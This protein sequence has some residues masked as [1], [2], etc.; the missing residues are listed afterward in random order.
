LAFQAELPGFVLT[1]PAFA[2]Y[3][4]AAMEVSLLKLK[5]KDRTLL[6]TPAGLSCSEA[7][8][9]PASYKVK[10]PLQWNKYSE[11]LLLQKINEQGVHGA[12]LSSKWENGWVSASS[13]IVGF[14]ALVV[15]T[16]APQFQKM[17]T[18][19]DPVTGALLWKFTLAD[20]CSG[21]K[22]ISLSLDGHW[23]VGEY[24]AS[25]TVIQARPPVDYTNCIGPHMLQLEYSDK[26]GNS[27]VTTLGF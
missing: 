9:K 1:I 4:N 24:N 8:R 16:I 18:I 15:D 26:T 13:K 27:A 20:N 11:H 2:L 17:D 14:Y 22:T 7:L 6:T 3:Q 10:V 23:I 21:V 19:P 5:S 25:I 12:V